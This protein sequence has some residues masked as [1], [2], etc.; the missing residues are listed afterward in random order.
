M[1]LGGWMV[2]CMDRWVVG[3]M[4]GWMDGNMEGKAVLRIFYINQK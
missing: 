3:W 2:E 1:F 4:G